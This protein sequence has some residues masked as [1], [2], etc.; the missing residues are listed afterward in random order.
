MRTFF[1]LLLLYVLLLGVAEFFRRL[2]A[3]FRWAFRKV[4]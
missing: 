1:S 3:L 2:R 4:H